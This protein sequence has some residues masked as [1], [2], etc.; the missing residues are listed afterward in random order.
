MQLSTRIYLRVYSLIVILVV[1]ICVLSLD[2]TKKV[3]ESESDDTKQKDESLSLGMNQQTE[4]AQGETLALFEAYTKSLKFVLEG[5][6]GSEYSQI[7]SSTKNSDNL[8]L[9]RENEQMV[10]KGCNVMMYSCSKHKNGKFSCYF[11]YWSFCQCSRPW[12]LKFLNYFIPSLYDCYPS[13]AAEEDFSLPLTSQ[14]EEK[15]PLEKE[16]SKISEDLE[17]PVGICGTNSV[18]VIWILLVSSLLTWITYRIYRFGCYIKNQIALSNRK[19][20]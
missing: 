20:R 3:I 18:F 15:M 17:I 5:M 1:F 6:F 12:K 8:P 11:Y 7:I 19:R 9:C 16:F 2:A 10:N 14:N 4:N 13:V